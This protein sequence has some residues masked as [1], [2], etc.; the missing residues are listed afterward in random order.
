M[1][2]RLTAAGLLVGLIAGMSGIGGG[3]LLAPIL[4]LLFGMKAAVAVGTDLV[5]SVPMKAI[6]AFT[7]VRQHTVDLRVVKLLSLGGIPGALAGLAAFALLRAT[8]PAAVLE[9]TARHAIGI[10]ILCAAFASLAL[11]LVR[12]RIPRERVA[13]PPVTIAIGAV[14]GFLVAITSIGSGSITLPLLLIVLPAIPLRS[15][16][17]SEIVFAALMIPV[18]AA[19]HIAFAN[20][21]WGVAL[22]LTAGALPGAYVGARLCGRLGEATLRPVVIGVLAFAGFKLL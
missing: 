12:R 17:G 7:H 20:V 1:D 9:H 15:L 14:V 11:H 4:I 18:A 8:L 19:G 13:R 3:S 2:L 10:V 6:A 21:D 5:F 16:I 22:S